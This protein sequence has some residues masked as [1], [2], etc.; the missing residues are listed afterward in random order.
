MS[1]FNPVT[2]FSGTELGDVDKLNNIVSNQ[3]ILWSLVPSYLYRRAFTYI[4]FDEAQ[5]SVFKPSIY[6]GRILVRATGARVLSGTVPFPAGTFAASCG[7]AIITT[8]SVSST[9][10]RLFTTITH[11][12]NDREHNIGP[13]GFRYRMYNQANNRI[14]SNISLHF[15]VFG[16]QEA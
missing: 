16:Y 6:A 2:S 15:I 12:S 8:P 11:Y 7:P 5:A 9:E 13:E 10:D 3:N 14:T 4:D 1:S